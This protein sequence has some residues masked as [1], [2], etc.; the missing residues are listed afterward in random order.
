MEKSPFPEIKITLGDI[1]RAVGDV[2]MGVVRHLPESG[3]PSSRTIQNESARRT[4]PQLSFEDAFGWDVVAPQPDREQDLVHQ[5]LT[6]QPRDNVA[7]W[8]Y[9]RLGE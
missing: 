9:E 2:V 7:P 1:A 4:A 5:A 8:V 3:Y 6:E